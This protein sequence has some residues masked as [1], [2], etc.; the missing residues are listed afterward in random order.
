MQSCLCSL[1]LQTEKELQ[2]ERKLQTEHQL[3]TE[4]KHPRRTSCDYVA[5]ASVLEYFVSFCSRQSFDLIS[6][7]VC[8]HVGT[9]STVSEVSLGVSGYMNGLTQ[10]LKMT[11]K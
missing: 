8:M 7:L 9:T 4:N 11:F 1:R 5:H 10:I 2:T 6:V 3:E